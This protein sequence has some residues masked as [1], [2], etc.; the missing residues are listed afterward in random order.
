MKDACPKENGTTNEDNLMYDEPFP[1]WYKVL[2]VVIALTMLFWPKISAS[3]K[4]SWTKNKRARYERA[5]KTLMAAQA[6]E[7]NAYEEKVGFEHNAYERG[8]LLRIAEGVT[9]PERDDFEDRIYR[10]RVSREFV[11][12]QK[13]AE[14]KQDLHELAVLFGQQ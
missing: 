3:I 7:L 9:E 14:H 2:G 4:A 10:S 1:L 5:R 11:L 13:K 8:M 6:S 12:N